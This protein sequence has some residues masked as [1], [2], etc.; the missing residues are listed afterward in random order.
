VFA[1]RN[2]STLACG[3]FV[4]AVLLG[5]ALEQSLP[6]AI[7]LL[8]FWHYYLYWLAFAFGAVPFD[9]FKRDAVAMKTVAVAALAVVYL[10]AP[11]DPVS[12]AVIAGGILLN[13]RA[14]AV[15]GIDR[16]YYGHE[17][18]DLPPQR[19]TAFPYSLIAHPM[20]VGNIAA[21]GGTL[22]NPAF[23]EQWWLLVGLHLALN[24]GLLAMELVG[25]RAVRIGGGFVFAG[26]LV[27]T[28]PGALLGAAALAC[29]G[30]LYHCY[31]RRTS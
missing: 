19:V 4:L 8:S 9:V 14:A 7:W 16:T 30:T 13:V 1:S 2:G 24:I 12:L 18:A 28:L 29:A 15:L 23:A 11:L 3:L 21:F 6:R 27:A 22:I 20:I 31:A 25:G 5:A 17:V 26:V 10:A